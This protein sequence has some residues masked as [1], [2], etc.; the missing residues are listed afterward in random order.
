MKWKNKIPAKE[1]TGYCLCGC[2]G[3]TRIAKVTRHDRGDIKGF[4]VRY[5]YGHNTKDPEWRKRISTWTKKANWNGGRTIHKGYILRHRNSFSKEDL[6]IIN[7]MF[8][9]SNRSYI[10]EHRALVALY[11]K[12]PLHKSETVRHLNGN[13]SNNSISN[14]ITGTQKDNFLDHDTAR[15]EVMRLKAENTQ[16]KQLVRRLHGGKD[17][18]ILWEGKI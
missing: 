8:S 15:K 9:R 4:P 18:K 10:L 14:L 13:R 5:I 6:K 16:L 1:R 2:G 11:Y 7:S 12:R 3:K 17:A